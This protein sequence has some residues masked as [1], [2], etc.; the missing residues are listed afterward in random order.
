MKS[1]NSKMSNLENA[2]L[3]HK[4]KSVD[5]PVSLQFNSKDDDVLIGEM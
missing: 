2:L 1:P 3:Q 5:S 4:V